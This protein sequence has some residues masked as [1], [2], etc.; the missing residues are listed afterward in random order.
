MKNEVSSLEL[1]H[2]VA[3]LSL[4][5]C[6][7]DK[8]Y[9][10][11]TKTFVFAIRK[12]G[13][14]KKLVRIELPK[15]IY[16]TN[17]KEE[18]PEKLSGFCGFLRKFI[19]GTR[20]TTFAQVNS[21]R[22]VKLVCESKESK[23][24]VYLEFFG[25][26]NFVI[27]E[28]DETIL[29]CLE[30]VLFKERM[31]KPGLTYALPERP[32][33]FTL[34]PTQFAD[35]LTGEN[36]STA[37][38]VGLGI[39][40]TFAHEVCALA[41]V[42]PSAKTVATDQTEKLFVAWHTLVTRKPQPLLVVNGEKPEE[43]IPFELKSYAAKT[44]KPV[45]SLSHGL[46]LLF[47]KDYGTKEAV[48]KPNKL[49]VVIAMQEQNA[50]RLE[51]EAAGVQKQGEYIYEQYQDVKKILDELQTAMKTHSLQELQEKTKNHKHVKEIDPKTGMVVVEF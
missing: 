22:V 39:G 21:E 15:F 51:D 30:T 42:T 9:Q 27:C 1:K 36:V 8:I 7:I 26:G 46:D 23:Y 24:H 28:P 2:L 20:V 32:N 44:T 41:G 3:E 40:G 4:T 48:A 18:M 25:K 14:E 16:F 29:H 37:L 5:S 13:E 38:A 35:V 50:T 45:A 49:A 11:E 17:N 10:P 43:V 34:T 31:V 33:A 19:E 47:A 12:P 6:W